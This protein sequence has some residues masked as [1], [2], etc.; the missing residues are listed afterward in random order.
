MNAVR[1]DARP[2]DVNMS[3][4]TVGLLLIFFRF[5]IFFLVSLKR[6]QQ[7]FDHSALECVREEDK[8]SNVCV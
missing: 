6:K 2:V 1:H 5:F 8:K 7:S 4:D 3:S